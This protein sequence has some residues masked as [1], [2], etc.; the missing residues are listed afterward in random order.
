VQKHGGDVVRHQPIVLTDAAERV[1]D[2]HIHEERERRERA[3]TLLE[4]RGWQ[5]WVVEQTVDAFVHKARLEKLE[6]RAGVTGNESRRKL[7]VAPRQ[8]SP[9]VS[10]YHD[11]ALLTGNTRSRARSCDKAGPVPKTTGVVEG[12]RD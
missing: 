8:M 10:E 4:Q 1:A 12:L 5:A 3:A 2:H 11:R 6:L 9:D 7:C